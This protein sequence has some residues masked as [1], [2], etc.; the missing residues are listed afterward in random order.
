MTDIAG[1]QNTNDNFGLGYGSAW[2][3]LRCLG[4]HRQRFSNGIAAAIGASKVEWLDFDFCRSNKSYSLTGRKVLDEE[5]SRLN[6]LPD[7]EKSV[8]A[9]NSYKWPKSGKQQTWDLI[10]K[11]VTSDSETEWLLCEAKANI[12]EVKGEDETGGGPVSKAKIRTVFVETLQAL[13]YSSDR[14]DQRA[15]IQ[16]QADIWMGPNFYQYANRIACLSH[17]LNSR[18]PA[19]LLMLYFCGDSFES[20][21]VICPKDRF[22]WKDTVLEMNRRLGLTGTSQLEKHMHHLAIDVATIAVTRIA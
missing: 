1:D 21:Q 18:I 4:Y 7:T 10:G 11:A 22:G 16:T 6:F 2:H 20:K 3:V 14:K 12:G 13:G 5:L 8:A 19:K 17:L 15:D 9:K